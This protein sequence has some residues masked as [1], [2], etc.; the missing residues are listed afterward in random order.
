MAKQLIPEELDQLIQ[1]YLTDG[2]LS[3]KERAVILKKAE[4]MGLDRDEVDL[5]L[6]AQEQKIEQANDAAVR[7]Q[8]GKTCPYCQGDV[9]LL[10][11]KCPHCEKIITA[12]ATEELQEIFDNLEEALINMKDGQQFS[13]NKATV[14]RYARKARMYYGENPKVQRL[15]EEVD[16][17]MAQAEKKAIQ[18]EKEAQKEAR[19]RE[20][21]E[22]METFLSSR[23]GKFTI[24]VV[25]LL[26]IYLIIF[27]WMLSLEWSET[28][29]TAGPAALVYVVIPVTIL[30]II[31]I[32][33]T[34][35]WASK[36]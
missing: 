6:D 3:D 36:G 7:K 2:V 11:T 17:E 30:F 32:I 18:A 29:F 16:A 25:I 8:K 35:R 20:N 1:E 4:G 9:P 23:W 15:L 12:Q 31:L 22:K 28:R 34:A 27:S 26:I 19:R 24:E 10:A 21:K 13:R 14:E 5:Y 33:K